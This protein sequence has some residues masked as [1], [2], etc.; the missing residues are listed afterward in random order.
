M[1]KGVRQR[2]GS[3]K[4]GG[5]PGVGCVRGRGEGMIGNDIVMIVMMVFARDVSLR[6]LLR[7]GRL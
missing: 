3:S 1:K 4:E 2:R 5:P 6:L 7:R